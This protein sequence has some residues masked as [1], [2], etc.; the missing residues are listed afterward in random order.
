[1]W[2]ESIAEVTILFSFILHLQSLAIKLYF[3]KNLFASVDAQGTQTHF[4]TADES[5][6]CF[7]HVSFNIGNVG[8]LFQY[9]LEVTYYF[10]P[11]YECI[12]IVNIYLYRLSN[13]FKF[14]NNE[15]E[16]C[17]LYFSVFWII[18]LLTCLSNSGISDH[19]F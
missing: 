16:S 12:N 11:F 18:S 4:S 13:S 9:I 8:W 3:E 1:M 10:N 19:L 2:N 7:N 14:T 5:L 17:N 15:Y 6:K